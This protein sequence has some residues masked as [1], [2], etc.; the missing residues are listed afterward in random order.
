MN[1]W[2]GI[3][4]ICY[5]ITA[6]S[7]FVA[8]RLAV[9]SV[10]NRGAYSVFESKRIQSVWFWV[11]VSVVASLWPITLPITLVVVYSSRSTDGKSRQN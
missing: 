9:A 5:L 4:A 2:F 7:F 3:G 8:L 1:I 11:S 6:V 10:S